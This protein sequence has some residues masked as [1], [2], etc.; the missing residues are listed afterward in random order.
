MS[1]N[2]ADLD[3]QLDKIKSDLLVKTSA[4]EPTAVTNSAVNHATSILEKYKQQAS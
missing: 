3:A 1:Q 4:A 2:D